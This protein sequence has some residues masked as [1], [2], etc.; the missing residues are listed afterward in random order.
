VSLT[1]GGTP[2]ALDGAGMATMVMSTAGSITVTATAADAAGNTTSVSQT[3]SVTNPAA[4][5]PSVQI[6]SP[7]FLW[8]KLM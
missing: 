1:V 4:S 6:T 3:L 2:V 7:V 5:A 8:I